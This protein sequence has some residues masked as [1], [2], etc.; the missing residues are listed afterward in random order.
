MPLKRRFGTGNDKGLLVMPSANLAILIRFKNSASTLASVLSAL[1]RQTVQPARIIGIDSGSTDESCAMLRAEG[2]QIIRREGRYHHSKALNFGMAHC[3]EEFVLVLSSHTVLEDPTT[4]DSMLAEISIP[5]TACVS[6]KWAES[7]AWSDAITWEEIQRV[8]L[9]F[10][11]IY[12]NSFGMVRRTLWER[13]PFDESLVTMED[14]AWALEQVSRGYTCRRLRFP[15]TYQRTSHAREFSF[16][17][18]TFHLAHRHGLAVRWLGWKGSVRAV[19]GGLF[20]RM[21]MRHAPI[22]EHVDRLRASLVAT[23]SCGRFYPT[24][25]R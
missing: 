9:R 21:C 4:I 24:A 6:G 11:S 2:A 12:S 22:R 14:Y 13:T 17:A 7:D 16:A 10:C 25:E 5:G 23:L 20:Q 1:R 3:R 8:G 19:V 18:T 15:F